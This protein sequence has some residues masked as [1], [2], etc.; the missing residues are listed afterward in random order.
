MEYKYE[1]KGK[2]ALMVALFIITIGALV[3][4]AGS[5]VV[6][7]TT[8]YN[9]AG[10]AATD[11]SPVALPDVGAY[12]FDLVATTSGTT[13]FTGLVV[14]LQQ[15]GISGGGWY[16]VNNSTFTTCAGSCVYFVSPDVYLG[17]RIRAIWSVTT[18]SATIKVT[19][20]EVNP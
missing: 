18:G 3:A 1:S 17:G 12:T 20:R 11:E 6:L 4:F 19:A 14:Y 8:S 16:T 2:V 9:V 13:S 7:S 10:A 5:T 15:G